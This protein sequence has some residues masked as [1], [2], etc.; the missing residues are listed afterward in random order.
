VTL[1]PPV[2]GASADGGSDEAT[3]TATDD[4]GEGD[5]DGSTGLEAPGFGALTAVLALL[6]A[7]LVTLRRRD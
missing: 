3:A 6:A 2:D 5:D 7:A 1:R 4:G